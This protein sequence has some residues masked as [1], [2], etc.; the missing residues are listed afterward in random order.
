[1]K[2]IICIVLFAFTFAMFLS[3]TERI[4]LKSVAS[5]DSVSDVNINFNVM[6]VANSAWY[7]QISGDITGE[8][9]VDSRGQTPRAFR[10]VW[11]GT[12]RWK[13][14]AGANTFTALLN[15]KLNTL[16]GTLIMRGIIIDGAHLGAQ[17]EV[18]GQVTT[19][20]PTN[21]VG[22]LRVIQP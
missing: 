2:K 8:L 21:L 15:G 4:Q 7:G 12:T 16:N 11:A 1:M 6:P 19:F 17:V 10:S 14:V 13:V 20:E 3:M 9:T 22:T 5:K 18:R